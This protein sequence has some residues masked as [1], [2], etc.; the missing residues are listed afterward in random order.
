MLAQQQTYFLMISHKKHWL[1]PAGLIF[2]SVVPAIA[3]TARL[4]QL[5]G[6]AEVTAENARFFAQPLPVVLHI[7]SSLMYCV[8]GAFQFSASIRRRYITLHRASGRVLI[9]LGLVS[10][11]S[12]LWMTQFYP[13]AN[14]DGVALYWVRLAVGIAMIYALCAGF[15]AIRKRNIPAHKAWMMRA[16]ALGIGAGT[17]VLTH[18]PWMLLPGLHGETFRTISM[19]AGWA[20][21]LAVAEYLIAKGAAQPRVRPA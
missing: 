1:I 11:A 2:L 7:V 12:G 14:F 4:M 20:I 6:G 8:V 10:A 17:Q 15:A 18:L 5:T 3:G 19:A 21:N 9:P 16:Y 13:N